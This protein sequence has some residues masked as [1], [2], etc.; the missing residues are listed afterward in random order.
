MFEPVLL[1]GTP[2]KADLK[3][4][5]AFVKNDLKKLLEFLN[6]WSRR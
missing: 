3:G 6:I 2:L 5:E 1:K 4:S